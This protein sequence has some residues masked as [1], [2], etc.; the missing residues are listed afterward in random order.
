MFHTFQVVFC[1]LLSVPAVRN[2]RYRVVTGP[3][4]QVGLNPGLLA[5]RLLHPFTHLPTPRLP[6]LE[7]PSPVSKK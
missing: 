4:W 2:P 7:R 6:S 3:K 1:L 5:R